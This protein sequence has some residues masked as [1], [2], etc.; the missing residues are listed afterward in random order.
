MGFDLLTMGEMQYVAFYDSERRMTIGSRKLPAAEWTFQQLPTQVVW[1][2]HNYVTMAIDRAGML[3]VSGNMHGV[4]LIYFRSTRPGDVTS[5]ERVAMTG[6][7]EDKCTYPEFFSGVQGELIFAYRDGGSGSG[8][9]I[10]NIYDEASRTW[11][12]LFD[13]PFSDGAGLMNAYF[14]GPV[15]GPDGFHHLTW[16]WRD[17]PDCSTNHDLCYARSRDFVHWETSTGDPI[18][19]PIRHDT[20]GVIVDPVPV[21]GGMLNGNGKIGF[22]SKNRVVLAFHKFDSN[23]HTQLYNARF[24][25]GAWRIHQ[26]TQWDYRWDFGGGGTIIGEIRINE[27]KLSNGRLEQQYSHKTA[28]SGILILDEETLK[29]IDTAVPTRWPAEVSKIR[30]V[31]PEMRLNLREGRGDPGYTM[32]W[33]TLP[34]LRD[35]PRP[36]P[37]PEPSLLEVLKYNQP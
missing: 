18:Q 23:G 9:Q 25:N 1:D 19:L 35:Q 20:P 10:Y 5:L 27:V 22:D 36:E 12:R 3:H 2:S 21:K 24:E 37:W 30:S 26:A 13:V 11:K 31:F 8:N 4:P 28:G 15:K 33:E 14:L 34:Q 6:K 16:I 7:N 29:P 32:R 17:T